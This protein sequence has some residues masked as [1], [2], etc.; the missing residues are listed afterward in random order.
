MSIDPNSRYKQGPS[1]AGDWLMQFL[2]RGGRSNGPKGMEN[3]AAGMRDY[4]APNST[5]WGERS[6][7]LGVNKGDWLQAGLGMLAGRNMQDGFYNV[8]GVAGNAMDRRRTEDKDEQRKQGIIAALGTQDPKERNTLLTQYAPE[9]M[10]EKAL[11]PPVPTKFGAPVAGLGE[12]GKPAFY[13]PGDDGSMKNVDGFTPPKPKPTGQWSTMTPDQ[14]IAEFGEDGPGTWQVHSLTGEKKQITGTAPR[15]PLVKNTVNSGEKGED[16]FQKHRGTSAGE[17]MD[18]IAANGQRALTT[19]SEAQMMNGF[20][21]QIDYQGFGGNALMQVQR[22]GAAVGIEIGNDL[23]AK[24]AAKTLTA[25]MGLA[26][27]A[28]LPGPMSDGDRAFLLSIPPNLNTTKAGNKALIFM[29]MKRAQ[30]DAD[31]AESMRQAN[32][33]T[34]EEYYAWEHEFKSSYPPLFNSKTQASMNAALRG[35]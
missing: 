27:K 5:P 11:T 15:G 26:L 35:E 33:Q 34:A 24:E 6:G 7:A 9:E 12:D 28:D 14:E 31:A 8:A 3:R 10:L 20:V 17:A 18:A 2:G 1:G 29:T 25:K 30:F 21:D 23:G 4:K 32:P 19:Q 16:A 13:I 22:I